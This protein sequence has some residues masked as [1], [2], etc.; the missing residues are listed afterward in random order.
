M[1]RRWEA[2]APNSAERRQ[3][4]REPA[5][6]SDE[7]LEGETARLLAAVPHKPAEP[8]R[9]ALPEAWDE[10]TGPELVL[11]IAR[12]VG[13]RLRRHNGEPVL[14]LPGRPA[15]RLPS[16]AARRHL[17]AVC[18]EHTGRVPSPGALRRAMDVMIAKAEERQSAFRR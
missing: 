16:P 17:A 1:L 3:L 11:A 8:P 14:H 10:L 7:A 12:H 5:C 2:L 18:E 15:C 13:A 4:M 6:L 9:A